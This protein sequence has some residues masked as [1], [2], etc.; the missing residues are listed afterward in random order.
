MEVGSS[1]AINILSTALWVICGALLVKCLS[2]YEARRETAFNR[3]AQMSR[4]ARLVHLT[5]GLVEIKEGAARYSVQE[6]D[7]SAICSALSLLQDSFGAKKVFVLSPNAALSQFGA[8]ENL[9]SVSG[10]VWNVITR[11]LL[12]ENPVLVSF[13]TIDGDDVLVDKSGGAT[14]C[15]KAVRES[16]IVRECYAIVYRGSRETSADGKKRHF[17]VAAGITALGTFGAVT[18]LRKCSTQRLRQNPFVWRLENDEHAL[19]LLKVRDPSPEGFQAY[20][21]GPESPGFLTIEIVAQ[22]RATATTPRTSNQPEI[23]VQSAG[24][25]P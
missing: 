17:V 20:S 22:Y 21:A 25:N 5:Y 16:G 23:D 9:V 24:A 15:Y 1:V 8:V 11:R 6:G 7:L 13:Q 4:R 3:F 18:W 2:A 14:K 19:L 12:E 10:P